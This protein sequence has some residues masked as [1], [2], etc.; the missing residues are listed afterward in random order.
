[1]ILQIRVVLIFLLVLLQFAAPLIHAH[2]NS[3]SNFGTSIH[4]P[5]FEQVDTLLKSVVSEFTAPTNHDEDIVAIS[6]G[7]KNETLQFLQT[8]NTIFVLLLSLIF[9]AKTQILLCCLSSKTEPILKSHFLNLISPRA[10]PFLY[11]R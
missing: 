4:L 5:E 6:T 11:V 2:K 10:P 7:I 3:A 8:D 9:I 1:M